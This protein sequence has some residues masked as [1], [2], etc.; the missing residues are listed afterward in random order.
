MKIKIKLE[1]KKHLESLGE[2]YESSWGYW[3]RVSKFRG[4]YSAQVFFI[5]SIFKLESSFEF[6]WVIYSNLLPTYCQPTANLTGNLTSNS[7]GLEYLWG[8]LGL[9]FGHQRRTLRAEFL[10]LHC[11]TQR[12]AVRIPGSVVR[13]CLRIAILRVASQRKLRIA[14]CE[15]NVS[16]K[17]TGKLISTHVK[18]RT[19]RAPSS[20][21][22]S[23]GLLLNIESR[24]QAA[25]SPRHCLCQC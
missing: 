19:A 22:T 18:L 20:L 3:F 1:Y 16:P 2:D 17:L 24:D 21:G 9:T 10:K 15:A 23:L 6:S 14:Q 25:S 13:F 5:L 8:V 11:S 12:L 7:D 4:I